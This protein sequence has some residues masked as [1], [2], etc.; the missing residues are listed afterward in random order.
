MPPA[1][2]RLTLTKLFYLVSLVWELS[3]LVF[4]SEFSLSRQVVLFAV[5]DDGHLTVAVLYLADN[6]DFSSVCCCHISIS[7]TL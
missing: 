6:I 7:L 2:L 5:F 3:N 4:V 1:L